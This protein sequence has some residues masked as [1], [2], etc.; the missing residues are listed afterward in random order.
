[1]TSTI[2]TLA[3]R[4]FG[5]CRFSWLFSVPSPVEWY[6]IFPCNP[7]RSPPTPPLVSFQ[8]IFIIL[9]YFIFKFGRI[10]HFRRINEFVTLDQGLDI[11]GAFY[12]LNVGMFAAHCFRYLV[13]S[14][15]FD[16]FCKRD[17][18]WYRWDSAPFIYVKLISVFIFSTQLWR[19]LSTV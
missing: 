1:M 14:T 16:A 18:I 2:D 17:C 19:R 9:Q 10:W 5:P 3:V 6:L 13:V 12:Y 7:R 15:C 11:W 8:F 4:V